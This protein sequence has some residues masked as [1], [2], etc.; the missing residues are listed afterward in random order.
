M[1]HSIINK[2]NIFRHKTLT[3]TQSKAVSEIQTYPTAYHRTQ[4]EQMLIF[5]VGNTMKSWQ[6]GNTRSIPYQS[7]QNVHQSLSGKSRTEFPACDIFFDPKREILHFSTLK[8]K[9]SY[10][11]VKEF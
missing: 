9:S 10:C 11:L 2:H 1:M 6:N 8:S 3:E 4:P 5:N 7:Q